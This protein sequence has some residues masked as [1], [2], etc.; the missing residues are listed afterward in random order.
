MFPKDKALLTSFLTKGKNSSNFW[1]FTP[2]CWT[3]SLFLLTV[4]IATAGSALLFT[5]YASNLPLTSLRS[6]YSSIVLEDG[7]S[8]LT[9]AQPVISAA[10]EH[11][12]NASFL[13]VNSVDSE[14][15]SMRNKT[16]LDNSKSQT[17]IQW[18]G[19]R[20]DPLIVH[21]AHHKTGTAWFSRIFRVYESRTGLP[22]VKGDPAMCID[23]NAAMCQIDN[24][25]PGSLEVL[26]S[27]PYKALL[28]VR[29]PRDVVVSGYFYH[30]IT[31]EPWVHEPRAEYN[32]KSYQQMLNTTSKTAGLN[33]EI[34]LI[35][36]GTWDQGKRGAYA[37]ALKSFLEV[38]D[39]NLAIVRYE[40]LW[41]SET[42]RTGSGFAAV[43]IWYG[44]PPGK[45]LN[46][47]VQAAV[48]V[49]QEAAAYKIAAKSILE[50]V[51]KGKNHFRKGTPGDWK[52]HFSKTNKVY[53]KK[54][55]V[56][57]L[58]AL[59]YEEDDKW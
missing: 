17:F 49:G 1:K 23:N 8:A 46:K 27:R 10:L 34:D 55:L 32:G 37:S 18:L 24:A 21:L 44:I 20:Q 11:R 36:G 38:K 6:G 28:S 40:D 48:K 42:R 33:M 51:D 26:Q 9:V 12:G 30:K 53:F 58:Q 31:H 35:T 56:N 45:Q 25:A 5:K 19:R 4:I 39:Q 54:K 57:M 3:F 13:V 47:F 16:S 14:N 2:L 29:D 43:G 7:S 52:N 15:Y 50:S 22:F 59:G 41:S